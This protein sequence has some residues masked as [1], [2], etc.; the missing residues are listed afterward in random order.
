MS[1][2]IKDIDVESTRY[3]YQLKWVKVIFALLGFIGIVFAIIFRFNIN[4]GGFILFNLTYYY[5]I[6]AAFAGCAFLVLPARKKDKRARWYDFLA[7]FFVLGIG[8]YFS[9]N[10]KEI[11]LV[12]WIPPTTLNTVLGVIMIILV[13]E[14][15]R[16]VNLIY[17]IVCMVIGVLPLFADKVPGIFSGI[18]FSF[19]EWVGQM[20]YGGDGLVGV[21][22]RVTGDYLIGYIMFAGVLSASGA[23][24]FFINLAF[25]LLGRFRGGPA[26]V[27]VLGSALFGSI[28]GSAISN[29]AAIGTFTIPAMKRLGFSPDYAGAVEAVASNGG[30]ITPPV[31][32]ALA[33]VMAVMMNMP[34]SAVVIC[35]VI[36]ALLYYF[37]LIMQVDAESARLGLKGLPAKEL[38]SIKTTLKDGW[39][40]ILVLVFLLWGLLYMKWEMQIPYYAA[41]LTIVLSFTRKSTFISIKKFLL[42]ITN[43][44][45]LI[46]Q[47]VAIMLSTGLV[48]AGLII[49]G[50]STSLTAELVHIV[51]GNSFLLLLMG[52][53]VCY[54]FGM[55][56]VVLPA[57]ILL[58]I[59]MAPAVIETGLH[60]T[61]VHFFIVYYTCLAGI[62]PP[63]AVASFF[64]AN[65]AKAS[66]M[67]TAFLS[68][69][70]ATVIYL[71][72]FFF[73]YNPSLI[74][75][76]NIFETLYLFPFCLIGI[77]LIAGGLQG[78]VIGIGKVVIWQRLFFCIAGILVCFPLWLTHITGV[79]LAAIVIIY[80]F[81]M[82]KWQRPQQSRL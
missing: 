31:M 46:A 6:L 51:S 76:G 50:T 53:A 20:V 49:T 73:V 56:G 34:Y 22:L 42:M 78:Y 27:T 70:L 13:L 2:Q 44:T 29:I 21:P 23:G 65:L 52:A 8:V 67:K 16:R 32:G 82:R 69:R 35:A 19:P 64:A 30:I 68:A 58:A 81:A 43:S 9:I 26:K 41:A 7:A 63:V 15:A 1:S 24:T 36:P 17:A 18:A 57:Y 72:P 14:L 77:T 80:I 66:P 71:L 5:I 28:S 45:N 61:A 33:F 12:G 40:F 60:P 48:C 11:M 25:A 39:T 37:S 38:P 59:T 79:V 55:V 3:D 62:T 74:L 10:S 75:A 47:M 54:I 4:V